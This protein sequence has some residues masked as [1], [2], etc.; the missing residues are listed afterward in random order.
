MTDNLCSA[1]CRSCLVD[2]CCCCCCYSCL[3]DC[4]Y[5][6]YHLP[7]IHPR[8]PRNSPRTRDP[9]SSCPA[10]SAAWSETPRTR[11]RNLKN[12]RHLLATGPCRNDT[13]QA[14]PPTRIFGTDLAAVEPDKP[15]FGTTRRPVELHHDPGQH[16]RSG[17][18]F[19]V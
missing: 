10:V 9:A 12:T 17:P 8:F 2:Y 19:L 13:V 6:R 18:K 3:V 4:C 14:C 5:F 15:Q 1:N 7:G 11:K 16:R